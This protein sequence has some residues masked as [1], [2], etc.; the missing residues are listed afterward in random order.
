MFAFK[1]RDTAEDDA[2]ARRRAT[3][4]LIAGII[5]DTRPSARVAIKS[6]CG[7]LAAAEGGDV[8]GIIEQKL[9][10]HSDAIAQYPSLAAR[11]RDLM[12]IMGLEAPELDVP[13]FRDLL[14]EVCSL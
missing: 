10:E 8:M 2:M 7:A 5:I 13:V 11:I 3:V 1:K 6:A 4:R 14:A 9:N 12:I